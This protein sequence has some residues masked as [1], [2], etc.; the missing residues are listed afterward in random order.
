MSPT[1]RQIV[2][3][4][5]MGA[6]CLAR[7]SFAQTVLKSS[8]A[9]AQMRGYVADA[10]QADKARFPQ[11]RKGQHCGNCAMFLGQPGQASAECPLF[12]G[13]QV[14]ASGWCSAWAK[15]DGQ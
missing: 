12:A 2:L 3:G 15:S 14:K 7:P 10:S 5:L 4:T 13:K 9:E 6:G 1:R 11:Y 8:D